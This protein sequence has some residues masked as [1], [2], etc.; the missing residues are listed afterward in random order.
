MKCTSINV[1]LLIF[2]IFADTMKNKKKIAVFVSSGI[3]NAV[4]IVPLLKALKNRDDIVTVILNSPFIDEDFLIFNRFPADDIIKIKSFKVSSIS[5]HRFD[6]SYLDY[7]SSSIKNLILA[8]YISKKVF[9]LRKDKL[10]VPGV[11][12]IK[13][14][15][16]IHAAVLHTKMVKRELTE[17]KF[18]LEQMRLIPMM[19]NPNLSAINTEDKKMISVQISSG[20]NKT[21]YKN[22]P[23]DYWIELFDLLE[24]DKLD[25][26]FVLIGDK[27]ETQIGEQILAKTKNKNLISLIGKTS[28]TEVSNILLDSCLYIGLDSGFM[29]L[30]VAYDIP[31]F[32]ILGAS[33]ENFIGY[34]KFNP[35]KH[36]VIFSNL[37]CRPCHGWIGQNTSRVSDPNKCPDFNCMQSLKPQF[38]YESLLN[39][40]ETIE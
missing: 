40:I 29:H 21:P 37:S 31:T 23:V 2:L 1:N 36:I 34:H 26:L 20:N 12:Y 10:L 3:G 25:Y 19:N 28:L 16:D 15:V 17:S 27:N 14:E 9:A 11:K 18:S 32:T 6:E 5:F 13:P 33:N 4:M 24:N 38:I 7:S 35:H 22:L 39:F 30:A 8:K